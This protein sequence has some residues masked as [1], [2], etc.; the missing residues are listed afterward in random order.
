ME[1]NA[2]EE[3]RQIFFEDY[4]VLR[5]KYHYNP[6]RFVE[7]LAEHGAV[8][9]VRRLLTTDEPQTGLYRLKELGRL[10]LSMEARV[11]DSRFS[12]LFTAEE[13]KEARKRL[14]EME[15]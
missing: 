8:E 10:D 14:A 3:L 2:N 11:C 4:K 6:S 15:R 1:V 9:T 13:I 12:S 5:S 7:M